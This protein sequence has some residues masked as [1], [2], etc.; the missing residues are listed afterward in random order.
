MVE[1]SPSAD[2]PEEAPRPARAPRK[3]TSAASTRAP[4]RAVAKA[5]TDSPETP[6]PPTAPKAKPRSTG[7][8]SSPRTPGSRPSAAAADPAGD[9]APDAT[10]R[11]GVASRRPA[12]DDLAPAP[13]P[14]PV[15]HQAALDLIQAYRS[16]AVP[17]PLPPTPPGPLP[18][19]RPGSLAPSPPGSL[20]PT[21][22]GPSDGSP[23][24]NDTAASHW[25]DTES[26]LQRLGLVDADG[27][28][29]EGSAERPVEHPGVF[30][31][32]GTTVPPPPHPI[33]IAEPVPAFDDLVARTRA[34]ARASEE[35]T[36]K[37]P[38]PGPFGP[39]P[40]TAEVPVEHP[41]SPRPGTYALDAAPA[42]AQ[43]APAS[44]RAAPVSAPAAPASLQ[45]LP[46]DVE[47]P[48]PADARPPAQRAEPRPGHALLP[49]R[50][51]VQRLLLP[52]RPPR[53]REMPV[54][55]P[56]AEPARRGPDAMEAPPE[57]SASP[58]RP[59]SLERA[60]PMPEPQPRP[61]R[62][63]PTPKQWRRAGR[64]AGIVAVL[65][66]A[67]IPAAGLSWRAAWGADADP[68]GALGGGFGVVGLALL[69]AG[70][71][72][73]VRSGPGERRP[74]T[75]P[76]VLARPGALA[77]V[78]GLAILFCAALAVN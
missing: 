43:A 54:G 45:A 34:R 46:A 72:A 70:A 4:R 58:E 19:T 42:S 48:T 7:S 37:L 38:Q 40:D 29:I 30:A 69:A 27:R 12:D 51:L 65:L 63:R 44:L 26:V 14:A 3:R 23:V 55:P 41:L 60:V 31:L 57:P 67:A 73:R 5:P 74:A 22:P 15:E 39:G 75:L 64:I 17:K 21:P 16:L 24:G 33:T 50:K 52:G 56:A 18:P 66:V 78:V 36:Q 77:I 76:Q 47:P 68:A 25:S 53:T 35:T 2:V 61:V 9:G 49:V 6:Q 20:A 11:R 32:D 28:P 8:R 71:I 62:R 10:A 1:D 59:A 13:A